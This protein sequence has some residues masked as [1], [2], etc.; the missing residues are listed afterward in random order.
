M[1]NRM[2]IP[3]ASRNI[4]INVIYKLSVG[5]AGVKTLL[6]NDK[7]RHVFDMS[8]T[9]PHSARIWHHITE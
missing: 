8:Y 3:S 9:R 2:G 5:C 1:N 7:E 6:C 4:L